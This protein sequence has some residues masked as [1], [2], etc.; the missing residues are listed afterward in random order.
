MTKKFYPFFIALFLHLLIVI[1]SSLLLDDVPTLIIT[2][3]KNLIN[4]NFNGGNTGGKAGEK[5]ARPL[6]S[7]NTKP[8]QSTDSNSKSNSMMNK[9]SSLE[10]MAGNGT[11]AGSGTGTGSGEATGVGS[12]ISFGEAVTSFKEPTYPRLALRRGIEGSLK[13]KISIS[14]EGVPQ[15]VIVLSSSGHEILD[16]AAVE[17][18]KTWKFQSQTAVYSVIKTIVFKIK[19]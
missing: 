15:E 8:N 12:G 16:N 10:S 17:A 3:T 14:P 4:V 7:T 9:S 11:G 18:A 13:I 2:Q 19:N 6:N 5:I 1:I